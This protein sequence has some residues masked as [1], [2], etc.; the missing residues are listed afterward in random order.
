M[1]NAE[2]LV[3]EVFSKYR[4]TIDNMLDEILCNSDTEDQI[5]EKNDSVVYR[6]IQS[7]E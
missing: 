6:S 7:F 5:N 1:K 2:E 4:D 3:D